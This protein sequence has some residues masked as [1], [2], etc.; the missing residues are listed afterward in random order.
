[1]KAESGTVVCV[2]G[3]GVGEPCQRDCAPG[4]A[5]DFDQRVC[6]TAPG[7]GEPCFGSADTCGQNLACRDGICEPA[8]AEVCRLN[9]PW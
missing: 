2:P 1:M 3:L 6:I 5:C 4:A 8:P 9:T 7:L